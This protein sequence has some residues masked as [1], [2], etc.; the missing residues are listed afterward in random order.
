MT[1][2]LTAKTL[3]LV[4]QLQS[5]PQF[6]K[7]T[8]TGIAQSTGIVNYDL[9]PYAKTL[10]PVITPLRNSIPRARGNGDTA[11]RWKA[12]TA[13]N[14]GRMFAGAS[15]GNRGA[16]IDQTEADYMA[17][18]KR[19]S[20]EN[21]ITEEAILAA[22]GFD[23][24][25]AIMA[26]NL[27]RATMIAEEE[28]VLT[29]N[30]SLALGTPATPQLTA[31]A[32]GGSL[33][34]GT[35]SVIVV[36]L[37]YDGFKRASVAGGVV[38][39]FVKANADGSSDTVN[40]GCSNKSASATIAVTGPNGKITATVATKPGAFAYAW[41][42]GATGSELLG[43][44]TTINSVVI[45]A[46]AAGAQNA[47][48]ITADKSTNAL[49]FDG[50]VVQ[51]IAGNG[52]YVSLDGA[53]LTSSAEGVLEIDNVLQNF[54]EQYRL[55]P[56]KI[57]CNAQEVRNI[58]KAT[59]KSGT[60]PVYRINLDS[61]AGQSTISGGALVASYWNKF[62][63]GGSKELSIE[64][65]PN[66]PPGKM[67]FDCTEIPYPLANVPGARRVK[68]RRDY[69]QVLW[70][71]TTMKRYTSVNVDQVLQVYTPFA[72]GVLDNIGNSVN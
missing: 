10:Y 55:T 20:L 5:N 33:A 64:I 65:H 19:L 57:W 11:T 8:T 67:F 70:P 37:T 2:E 66:L 3:A 58:T 13:I 18:Y 43:A 52:Q 72:L 34:S 38:T 71:Q 60:A 54:W 63:P 26:D 46:A 56:T 53:G 50:L 9:E 1:G 25:L 7:A 30:N 59:L 22:E 62:S 28:V 24:A 68:A 40:G 49:V 41:Y 44:I 36:A 14:P 17:A 12:I 23:N 47:S 4:K 21:F 32:S 27:L 6:V 35:Y 39:S 29:G 48:A 61:G 15:E 31:A 45:T 16:V 42:W 51:A 69:W